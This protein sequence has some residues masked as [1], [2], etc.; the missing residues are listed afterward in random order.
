MNETVLYY[1]DG[2][3]GGSGDDDDDDTTM[4]QMIRIQM[5]LS[6]SGMLVR[7]CGSKD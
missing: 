5:I 1:H 2:G 6:H 7:V 4:I 3:D